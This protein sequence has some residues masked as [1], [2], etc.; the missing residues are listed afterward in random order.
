MPI[1]ESFFSDTVESALAQ[2]T[3]RLG[4]E[5]V[6]VGSRRTDPAERHLGMYEV[7]VESETQVSQ[8]R[9][10]RQCSDSEKTVRRQM[11]A[12]GQSPPHDGDAEMIHREING[13]RKLLLRCTSVLG[14]SRPEEVLKVSDLLDSADFSPTLVEAIVR[15]VTEHRNCATQ[16]EGL[17]RGIC[18][19][20][21]AGVR[22][23]SGI[24]TSTSARRVIA[25]A[26]PAGGGKT[27]TLIKLAA[28]LGLDRHSP[29]VLIGAD[30]Y[31]IAAGDQLR[32]YAAI[33]GIGCE[34][35]DTPCSLLR[36]LEENHSKKTVLIDLPGMGQREPE[37]MQ[38][39]APT[40]SGAEIDVHL[41][42]PATMRYPDLARMV[43]RFEP[44]RPRHLVFTHLDETASYGGVLSIAIET[45][46]PVSFLCAGQS[47]PED[48]EPATR[49]GL[50]R[51]F[52]GA[53]Q[54]K[55]TSA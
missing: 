38:E 53:P 3:R 6:L 42:V 4:R 12:F 54:A 40:L 8:C 49:A 50:L 27:T 55:A 15:S 19:V 2:A 24:E 32:T 23:D 17:L 36:S 18:D 28:R 34:V 35:V 14:L 20:I 13:I 11:Y 46:R 52:G 48:I 10:A 22:I 16:P 47:I 51:L 44:L 5:S 25:F 31:R 30:T 7:I 41:V 29:T 26:G 9:S 45:G 21:N 39:W 37:L 43:G 33:L 1:R